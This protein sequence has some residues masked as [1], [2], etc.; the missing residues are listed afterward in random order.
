MIGYMAAAVP[1]AGLLAILGPMAAGNRTETIEGDRVTFAVSL[2]GEPVAPGSRLAMEL[3]CGEKAAAIAA[4]SGHEPVAATRAHTAAGQRCHI[5]LSGDGAAR[6]G[7]EVVITVAHQGKVLARRVLYPEGD[8]ALSPDFIAPSGELSVSASVEMT[9]RPL[10]TRLRVMEW[11]IWQ[12]GRAAGGDGNVS[13]LIELIRA[14]HADILFILETYGSGQS[15][16]D[17]LNKGLP[18]ERRYNGT[19]ITNRPGQPEDRDNLWIF[20]RFPLV[21][22]YA[23]INEKGLD[24]F[25]FGGIK[26]RLPDGQ[27]LHLFNIWL[28]H[29]PQAWGFTNKTAAEIKGK[30]PRTYTDRD[31]VATDEER[32]LAMAKI[33]LRTRLPGFVGDDPSPVIIAGDLN[34]MSY[35]DWSAEFADAPNHE[36]L[37]LPWPVTR[38]FEE[39]GFTDAYRWAHPDAGRFPGPTW[40]PQYGYGHVPGRIDYIWTRGSAVRVLDAYTVDRRLPGHENAQHPFYSDHAAVVTD[41]M[42]RSRDGQ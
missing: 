17:G 11:N 3:V 28:W 36:G 15:I 42:I 23:P 37:V 19:R 32:R 34:T 22:Q 1:L 27:E 13:D 26:V 29:A 25:N 18:E 41:L 14:Q 9:D 2:S 6:L 38:L 8:A 39:A 5:K 21:K 31:I 7:G 10:G 16:L 33:A 30:R 12:G 20:S 24:S 35:H 4:F 40:S